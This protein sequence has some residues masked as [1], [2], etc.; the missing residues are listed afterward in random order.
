MDGVFAIC[1][2]LLPSHLRYIQLIKEFWLL[3]SCEILETHKKTILHHR[4]EPTMNL[5]YI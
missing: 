3:A 2:V 5:T 4:R 1:E